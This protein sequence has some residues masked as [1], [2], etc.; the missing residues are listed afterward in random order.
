MGMWDF[1]AWG[2]DSA[3][4]WF[5]DLMEATKLR[6]HWLNG[7][8][9][10]AEDEYEEVRAAVWLF[11]QL[12]RTYIWPIDHL[13]ADLELAISAAKTLLANEWLQEEAPDFLTKVRDELADIESRRKK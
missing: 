11:A 9:G 6:E 1:E 12:G 2:N 7:I 3:A 13:D 4:D 8:Q 10:D 5:G